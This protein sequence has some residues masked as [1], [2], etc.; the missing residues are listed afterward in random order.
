MYLFAD[1]TNLLNISNSYKIL[2]KQLNYDLK[3]LYLWLLAN[4][5]SLTVTKTDLIVFRKQEKVI[6]PL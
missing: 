1:D 4:K 6:K 3:G 5:I 2:Q